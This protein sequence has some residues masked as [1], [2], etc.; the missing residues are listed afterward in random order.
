MAWVLGSCVDGEDIGVE[1]EAS[2]LGAVPAVEL[3]AWPGGVNE[4]GVEDAVVDDDF[5]EACV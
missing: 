2:D 4:V 5:S 3:V 1:V